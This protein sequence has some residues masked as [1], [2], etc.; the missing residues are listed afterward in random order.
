[1]ECYYSPDHGYRWYH[2]STKRYLEGESALGATPSALHLVVEAGNEE[3]Y[4]CRYLFA[5]PGWSDTLRISDDPTHASFDP[6]MTAWGDSNLVV[7]WVDYKYSPYAWTGDIL[8]RRSTNNGDSWLPEQQ[9]TFNHLAFGKNITQRNDSLFMV[10]DEIVLDGETNS[11]EVFFNLS[12]DGGVTWGEP[13]RVTH[14]PW[15]SVYPSVAI[16]GSYTHVVYCDARDDTLWG[17]HKC[18]YYRRGTIS[19][20][21]NVEPDRQTKPDGISIRAY[22]NPFNSSTI[23]TYSNLEGGEIEIYNINGQLITKLGTDSNEEGQ[24]IW[25]ARDAMGNKVSSGIYFA[26]ARA[27]QNEKAIK[28]LYLK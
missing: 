22:P 6:E 5:Q 14:S 4:Y 10:Y 26:R 28:L 20:S 23:I 2:H 3:I 1:M 12:P 24:I 21:S 17:N 19:G 9:L 16:D 25:D 15:R 13:L 11:E 27:S 18:L 7:I 8:M